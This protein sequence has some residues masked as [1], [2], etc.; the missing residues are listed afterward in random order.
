MSPKGRAMNTIEKILGINQR[1]P[2]E[3]GLFEGPSSYPRLCRWSLIFCSL[4]AQP[5][6]VKSPQAILLFDTDLPDL[7]QVAIS[8][9]HF[10]D[11][12]LFQGGHAVHNGLLPQILH[13]GLSLDQLF[14]LVRAD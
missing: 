8:A 10:L 5:R 12:V 13:L 7:Y 11:A 4:A 14:H 1:S 2:A 6:S 9:K 3:D